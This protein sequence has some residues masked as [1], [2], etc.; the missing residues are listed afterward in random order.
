MHIYNGEGRTSFYQWDIDQKLTLDGLAVGDEVHFANVTTPEALI[1]KAYEAEEG[2]VVVDVPNALLA[3]AYTLKAYRFIR[4]EDG[5]YTE[6]D[7]AFEVQRRPKPAGY[8]Y[9]E[10]EVTDVETV[11]D[12]ALKDAIENGE[13]GGG[14]GGGDVDAAGILAAAHGYTDQQVGAAEQRAITS[15]QSYVDGK[16]GDIGAVLDAI[17]E[18]QNSLID[19]EAAAE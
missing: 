6:E 8:I 15:S 4:Q 11:V 1:V 16:V 3:T 19:E 5:S 2:V 17:I 9:T 12:K 7:Y 14:G 13:I 10:M 18:L